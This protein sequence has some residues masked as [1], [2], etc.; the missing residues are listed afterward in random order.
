MSFKK[1]F[2]IIL[3]IVI[4]VTAV[5]PT[6]ANSE[7][8]EVDVATDRPE[9]LTLN[10]YKSQ[11]R[12]EGL[13]VIT[14]A[15]FLKIMS[16]FRTIFRIFTG[17]IFTPK[18]N[19]NVEFDELV[20]NACNIVYND[21]G[22]DIVALLTSIPD[23]T[24]PAKIAEK[25]FNI[26]TDTIREEMYNKR[27]E[28]R[29]N[30]DETMYTVYYFL[31]AYLAVI[32]KCT[33]YSVPTDDPDVYEVEALLT[34]KDGTTD[35]LDTD[36]YINIVTGEC[37][38]K[39]GSGLAKTGFNF[40]LNEALVYA[41]IDGWMREFG[42]CVFYDIAANSFP[43]LWHYVTRRFTFEY[44]GLEWMIQI[45]KGNYLITNGGEVGVY[46]REPGSFGTFYNSATN[47]QLMEMSLQVYHGDELLVN[48]DPQMHWWINGFQMGRR[49]Y[50]P[51][52]LTMKF[53]IVMPDEEMLNA[54][55]ESIDNHYRHDVTY[56]VDGLKIDV[57]W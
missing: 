10:E 20:G 11:L 56:T 44:D 39:D 18:Q 55:C 24:Q 32:E 6:F 5:L 7:V 42:F 38:N 33:I 15:Q 2:S 51:S 48:Q 47:D 45:W 14:T 29:E 22:L 37:S 31:G 9:T 1:V 26:D 13:P 54:F 16:F 3:S 25:V 21:C 50:T 30:N 57:V 4:V 34:F 46:N 35:S 12:D 52:K 27:D 49:R 23:F 28:A 53:S 36:I 17:Q 40:K 8:S 19:F 41:T 43:L